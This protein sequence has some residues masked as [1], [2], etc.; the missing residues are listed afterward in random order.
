VCSSDLPDFN[1]ND[2]ALK[3]ILHD[4]IGVHIKNSMSKRSIRPQLGQYMSRDATEGFRLATVHTGMEWRYPPSFILNDDICKAVLC[5]TWCVIKEYYG[6]GFT[7][8]TYAIDMVIPVLRSLELYPYYKIW[9]EK[10]IELFMMKITP[11]EGIDLKEARGIQPPTHNIRV[12]SDIEWVSKYFVS[13][14][15]ASANIISLAIYRT[16]DMQ[17]QVY[18]R[19]PLSDELK[20]EIEAFAA[21]HLVACHYRTSRDVATNLRMDIPWYSPANFEIAQTK[22]KILLKKIILELDKQLSDS[23]LK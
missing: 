23:V 2:T 8:D 4:L 14:R 12:F 7:T 16:T 17:V 21:N 6:H 13:T 3:H 15:I 22:F 9:I 19:K 5:T 10:F 20:A 18:T 11:M 1:I